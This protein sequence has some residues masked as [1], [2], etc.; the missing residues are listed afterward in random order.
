MLTSVLVP[1]GSAAAA[2]VPPVM[3]ESM[4]LVPLSRT[5]PREPMPK[6]PAVRGGMASTLESGFWVDEEAEGVGER[7]VCKDGYGCGGDA[8]AFMLDVGHPGEE[9]HMVY[10]K[11]MQ[12][13]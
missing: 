9:I 7:G 5:A 2:S 11:F 1:I 4:L 6:G 12:E 8:W 10:N 3:A 13:T